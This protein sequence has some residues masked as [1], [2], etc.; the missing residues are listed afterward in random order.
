MKDNM[1]SVVHIVDVSN[2]DMLDPGFLGDIIRNDRAF[3]IGVRVDL[4]FEN[5]DERR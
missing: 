1:Y 3:S 2:V 4:A 5:L